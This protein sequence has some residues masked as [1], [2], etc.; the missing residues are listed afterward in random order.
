M[1]EFK[2]KMVGKESWEGFFYG[3]L[4]MNVPLRQK[5]NCSNNR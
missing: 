1:Y 5:V 3:N 2:V 4:G